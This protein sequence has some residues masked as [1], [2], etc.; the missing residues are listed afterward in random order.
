MF[1]NQQL[2]HTGTCRHVH[3]ALCHSL[4]N[5]DMKSI[6]KWNSMWEAGDNKTAEL[7][8][9]SGDDMRMD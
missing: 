4:D 2:T 3:T 6:C 1:M 8:K 9:D 5:L 7:C